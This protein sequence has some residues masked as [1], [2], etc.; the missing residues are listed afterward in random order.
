MTIKDAYDIIDQ[1]CATFRGNRQDHQ[2]INLA[3]QTIKNELSGK[4]KSKADE[5][6]LPSS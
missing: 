5:G 2:N 4:K 1:V 6:D 3:L